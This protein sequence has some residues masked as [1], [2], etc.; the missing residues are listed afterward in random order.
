MN[1]FKLTVLAVAIAVGAWG[2]SGTVK[3]D[4]QPIPGA[5][6]RAT[7]GDRVLT[8]LTDASGAFTIDKMGPGMW[9]IDVSMFG[10]DTARRDIQIG[11]SPVKIDL[12]LQLREFR[13]GFARGAGGEGGGQGRGGFGGAAG[14]GA[15]GG[16]RAGGFG[17]GGGGFGRGGNTGGE[18]AGAGANNA[19][20]G[21]NSA[22]GNAAGGNPN[23]NTGTSPGANSGANN[24]RV[25]PGA[26]Q[27]AFDQDGLAA[28][29]A[30]AQAGVQPGG[31]G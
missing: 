23:P 4:G 11:T 26:N 1:F 7:Q 2:Q 21:T 5:T 8:T 9:T 14:Q 31:A 25:N 29:A 10:F 12:S 27:G 19:E 17:R 22:A 3:S 20:G 15:G 28:A 6:V 16:G 13:G 24:P 30:E 18:N